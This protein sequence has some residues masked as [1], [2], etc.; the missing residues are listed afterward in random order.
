MFS[1]VIPVYNHAR[2][3]QEAVTSA[4]CSTLV[5]EVLL[6]DD[7]SADNSRDVIAHLTRTFSRVHNIEPNGT[8]NLGAHQRLNQLCGAAR[9][10]WIA[11]LNSDDAFVAGR[12]DLIKNMVRGS[13]I[14]FVSGSLIIIGESG[15]VIGTKR[16]ITEPEYPVPGDLVNLEG[17][18]ATYMRRILCNQ[19]FLATTSNMVFH[20]RLFEQIGGFR[21]FRY[22]HDWDFALRATSLAE[23]SYTAVP[24]TKYRMH[25]RNTIREASHN[26][27]GEVVRMFARYLDDFAQVV[28]DPVCRVALS[29]NRHLGSFTLRDGNDGSRGEVPRFG[30]RSPRPLPNHVISIEPLLHLL[31]WADIDYVWNPSEFQYPFFERAFDNA[32]M[33][34]AHLMYDFIILARTL[35]EPPLVGISSLR[36]VSVFNCRAAPLILD[37]IRPEEPLRGRVIRL[38]TNKAS[39]ISPVNLCSW[40]GF[41]GARVIGAD[42]TFGRTTSIDLPTSIAVDAASRLPVRRSGKRPIIFVLP[43]FMAVGG[44]ERNMIEVI[45]ALRSEYDFVVIT[46]ER[47]AKHQ[48]SLH[49]QLDQLEVITFDLAELAEA[50]WHLSMIETINRIYDADLVWLCNGSPWLVSHSCGL[51]QIFSQI[52]IVDQQVYDVNHGWINH[53][54]DPGIQSFDRFIAINSKIKAKFINEIG[55]PSHRIDLIYHAIDADRLRTSRLEF[56]KEEMRRSNDIPG[57]V[58]CF[59]FIGRLTAQKQP[60]RFLDLVKRSQNCGFEDHFLLVGDGELSEVCDRFISENMLRRLRRIQFFTDIGAIAAMMDGLIVTSEFEGLPIVL[61]ETLTFG[62][63]ALATDVGDIRLVIEEYGSGLVVDPGTS[64]DALWS[65]FLMWRSDLPRFRAH[66]NASADAILDRFSSKTIGQQ[67]HQSWQTAIKGSCR[68]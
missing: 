1:V 19:N 64:G 4:L 59:A 16:G 28:D 8:G 3:L 9:S 29:G 48:G 45:R 2:Y 20:K 21:N 7:G 60:L 27:D 23:S 6:A 43:I 44:A 14:R 42:I 30:A 15:V 67:Y 54:A 24:M 33:C 55:I 13:E 40:P 36:E 35:D 25:G 50:P 38:P 51:R 61:L 63:P 52:P 5:D 49:F 53:Y 57:D 62:R 41:A 32:V 58:N 34:L 66:A 31:P 18:D 26:I 65:S 22:V 17:N 11:V 37:G 47:L 68:P 39:E 46:T 12:F 10:D 56:S